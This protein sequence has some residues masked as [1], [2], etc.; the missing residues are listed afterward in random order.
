MHAP[1]WLLALALL[2]VMTIAPAQAQGNLPGTPPP[3]VGHDQPR[4]D[5][6]SGPRVRF[7]P[8]IRIDLT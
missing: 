6:S 8:S 5:D 7:I 1:A 4:R 2:D 3:V